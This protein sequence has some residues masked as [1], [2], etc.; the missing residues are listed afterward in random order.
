MERS[1]RPR[2]EEDEPC[3]DVVDAARRIYN[4]PCSNKPEFDAKGTDRSKEAVARKT[5]EYCGCFAPGA[6]VYDLMSQRAILNDSVQFRARFGTVFRESGP[7]LKL[8]VLARVVFVPADRCPHVFVLDLERHS[9][10]VTPVAANLDGS[11]GLRGPRQQD[12]WALYQVTAG[13][14]AALWLAPSAAGEE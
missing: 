4:T 11:L 8:S 3:F 12:L 7:G 9:S 14:V 5:A 10:L 1:K 13:R 2:E 6:R